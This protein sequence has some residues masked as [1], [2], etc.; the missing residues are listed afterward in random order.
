MKYKMFAVD[1]DGTLLNSQKVIP[2]ENRE[3]LFKLQEN[4]IKVVFST[5]R[6]ME[7]AVSYAKA[8]GFEPDFVGANGASMAY[9]EIHE[10][11]YIEKN[12]IF[13]YAKRCQDLGLGFNI[14]T[15]D[16]TYYYRTLEFYD[17]YYFDNPMVKN[18]EVL[19]KS[20]FHDMEEIAADLLGENVIKM[21]IYKDPHHGVDIIWDELDHDQLNIIRPEPM[22][23]EIMNKEAS[24]GNSVNRVAGHYSINT[25]EIITI[26]DGG[27]DLSMFEM[28]G[29]SIS[30]G[31]AREDIKRATMM[32]ADTNDNAG[33]AKVLKK[34]K[35]I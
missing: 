32:T 31:N 17:T 7:S 23:V 33:V 27:N 6:V 25:D 10:N 18:S 12:K 20:L 30:M 13:K 8:I 3:A 22:Y 15:E 19:S 11:L 34:L 5:G 29:L 16:H 1:L 24:K 21:D 9:G 28:C 4:G 14:I 2:E 35:L 26:G